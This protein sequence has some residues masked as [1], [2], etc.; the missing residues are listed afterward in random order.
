[1][2]S[3]ALAVFQ[4]FIKHCFLDYRDYFIVSYID[5]LLVYSKDF[6]GHVKH[7]RLN[8]QIP[9]QHGVKIKAKKYQL[10]KQEVRNLYRIV[11]A[12]G[13]RLDPNN[14]QSVTE[15]AKTQTLGELRRLL[16]MVG[17]FRKY[18]ANFSKKAAPLYK[19]LKKNS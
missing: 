3:C 17:Y 8:L 9:Q 10:F 7:L 19:F 16:G 14:I 15:L 13:Y 1:M 11:T 18:I 6:N 2:G 5:E 12:D 4:R